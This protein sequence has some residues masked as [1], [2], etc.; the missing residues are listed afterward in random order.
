MMNYRLVRFTTDYVSTAAKGPPRSPL[1]HILTIIIDVG[2]VEA[3]VGEVGEAP[4]RDGAPQLRRARRAQLVV[5]QHLRQG[6]PTV[7][8]Q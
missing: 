6:Q 3:E 7:G 5:V 2:E 1:S 8:H 4:P